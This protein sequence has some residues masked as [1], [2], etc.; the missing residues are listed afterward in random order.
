MV[1]KEQEE[2]SSRENILKTIKQ[3]QPV[4]TQ[5]GDLKMDSIKY[6][7]AVDTFTS[8][9]TGIGGIVIHVK[10]LQEITASVRGTFNQSKRIVSSVPD[11]ISGQE[12]IASDPH[13]LED[14]ELAILQGQLGV[15]EN[16]AIW[17]TDSLMVDRALPFICQ[18]L[19][20]V[21]RKGQV[22]HNLQEAYQQI[23]STDYN[24]GVF[25]AGPSKTADIEQSLVLGAHGAKSLTV[26]LLD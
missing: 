17:I 25:V 2:M 1:S 19:A 12:S 26:F 5:L 18:H 15:A 14:V 13:Q 16:G 7:D 22:V 8:T 3:N 20:L 6:P 24:L 10:S 21:L 4:L 23:G 11:I 9:L